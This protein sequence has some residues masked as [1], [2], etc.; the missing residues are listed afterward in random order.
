MGKPPEVPEPAEVPAEEAAPETAKAAAPAKEESSLEPAPAVPA[1]D[2]L[3]SKAGKTLSEASKAKKVPLP[4]L[5]TERRLRQEAEAR[6]KTAKDRFDGLQQMLNERLTAL[7]PAAK[8][9]APALPDPKVDPDGYYQGMIQ[10][11]EDNLRQSQSVQ[12][13]LVGHVQQQRAEEALSQHVYAQEQQYVLEKPDYHNA[14]AYA[15]ALRDRH[16]QGLGYDAAARIALVKRDAVALAMTA[17]QGGK[18][19]ADA[20]YSY[21]VTMG[22]QPQAPASEEEAMPEEAAALASAEEQLQATDT[23]ATIAH[24]QATSKGMQRSTGKAKE[25]DIFTRLSDAADARDDKQF[26]QLFSQ[27]KR[28]MDNA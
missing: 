13:Q 16:Y 12:Q 11:L 10:R 25:S 22:W 27:M 17:L 19:T 7:A 2:E 28:Q 1:K 4:E 23:L 24:G 18:N 20:F 26:E 15:K 14:I 8:P 5:I 3:L 9:D 21:A 6:E